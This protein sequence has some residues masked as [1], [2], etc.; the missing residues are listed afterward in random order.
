M[1]PVSRAFPSPGCAPSVCLT[2]M[3]CCFPLV[4]GHLSPG[5]ESHDSWVPV[6]CYVKWSDTLGCPRDLFPFLETRGADS[7]LSDCWE[8]GMLHARMARAGFLGLLSQVAANLGSSNN[9]CLFSRRSRGWE[10]EIKPGS[11]SRPGLP[12]YVLPKRAP[13]QAS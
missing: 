8:H 4:W 10:F 2:A 13:T 12:V 11:V 9:Q 1:G 6:P 3:P 7:H 5:R